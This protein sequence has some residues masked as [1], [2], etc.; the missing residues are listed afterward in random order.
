[1]T[2]TKTERCPDCNRAVQYAKDHNHLPCIDDP[3]LLDLFSQEKALI[4][5]VD[6]LIDTDQAAEIDAGCDGEGPMA[7]A[8]VALGRHPDLESATA[9]I[10]KNTGGESDDEGGDFGN[11]SEKDQEKD[12]RDTH[13]EGR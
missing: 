4:E 10:Y 3:V 6:S 9:A 5:L 11:W 7:R 1:M 8:L 12:W 2:T 13:G